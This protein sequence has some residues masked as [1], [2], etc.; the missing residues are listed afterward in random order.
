MTVSIISFALCESIA[1]YGLVLFLINGGRP[2]FYLFLL[3][4]LAA[5]AIHFPRFGRWQEWVQNMPEVIQ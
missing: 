4:A 5:F 2:E 3:V 1:I